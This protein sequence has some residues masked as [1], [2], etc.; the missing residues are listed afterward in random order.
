ML[1]WFGE[2]IG[3]PPDFL[4]FT[5][6]ANGGGVIQARGS[7]VEGVQTF[8]HTLQG[9]ASECNFVALLAAR[10]EV[11]K[12]LR[13]RFPFVEEGLLM[14][15]LIAYCS[16]EVPSPQRKERGKG[17]A[18][19]R[20]FK[21]HSSVEKAAMIAMVKLRILET[22]GNFRLRGETLQSAITV[23]ERNLPSWIMR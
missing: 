11:M 2:M 19:R 8:R 9:S 4:P 18:N 10:F 17:G 3:L 13:Q 12:E 22:D 23:L 16:K 21:A 7:G 14:S 1:Q 6:S 20:K 15:K 5:E